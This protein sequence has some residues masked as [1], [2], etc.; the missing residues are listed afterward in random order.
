RRHRQT[1]RE[2]AD[3]VDAAGRDDQQNERSPQRICETTGMASAMV[4]VAGLGTMEAVIAE[5]FAR[6][7]LR[8]IVVEADAGALRP[9]RGPLERATGRA[10]DRGKLTAAEREAVL[11]RITLTTSREDLREADLVVEA[12]PEV[13]SL[14][15][16][17][18]RDLDSICKPETVLATNTSSLSV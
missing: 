11:G 4:G 9:V 10:L 13:M 7:A 14:K 8:I 12:I 17:L 2:P 5:V 3:V 6:G 1:S 16:A 18:M 15:T